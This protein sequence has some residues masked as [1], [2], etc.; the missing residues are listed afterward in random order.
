LGPIAAGLETT[1]N[2]PADRMLPLFDRWAPRV[3]RARMKKIAPH[4]RTFALDGNKWF[5]SRNKLSK[6]S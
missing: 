4:V 2:D 1:Q 6:P 3:L 5:R